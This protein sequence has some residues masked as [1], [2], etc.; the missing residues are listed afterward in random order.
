MTRFGPNSL[1]C[2]L[3]LAA[4]LTACAST[5]ATHIPADQPST[6][7]LETN[8]L[9]EV[10]QMA[11]ELSQTLGS[12][13][14]LVVFDL[15]NTL[16]AMEQD[17]GSNQWYDWQ[18]DLQAAEPC[19]PK[20]LNN[21]LAIQGALYSVS[22][23]RLTQADGP[24]QVRK[25]QDHGLKVFI[26]TSR[27]PDY[28]FQTL[29]ELRRGGFSFYTSAIGPVGGY[30]EEFIPEAGSRASRYEDGVFMTAGQHKGDMLKALL[31]KTNTPAPAVVVMADDNE[32]NLQAVM[33]AFAGSS[34]AVKAFRYG[35]EDAIV[36][37]FDE[38]QAH[39]LWVEAEP[40]LRQLQ[41]L[42]GA[43]NY[44]L[45]VATTPDGCETVEH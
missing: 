43:D 20:V 40:A 10:S 12:D 26:L 16:L 39:Q 44:D 21:R 19:H 5:P 4:L 3:I 34:T 35:R 6:Q 13:Q 14:V 24:E 41:Q 18:R 32:K 30:A 2:C 25:L 42:F 15:D 29:R 27:G 28:R 7:L 11:M 45:P 8:D 1:I 17:L 37:E 38:E 31:D 9:A 22:A 36:D 23:M 33:D